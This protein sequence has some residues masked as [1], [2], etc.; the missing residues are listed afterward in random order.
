MTFLAHV[1]CVYFVA[2]LSRTKQAIED[3]RCLV[4]LFQASSISVPIVPIYLSSSAPEHAAMKYD[5]ETAV[6]QLEGLQESLD[7]SERAELE[8]ATG[9]SASK[10]GLGL[11]QSIPNIISKPLAIDSLESQFK[12]RARR[13]QTSACRY[14]DI[15]LVFICYT[16]SLM[17]HARV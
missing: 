13:G 1:W 8:K 6:S 16:L 17:V 4:H 12:V 14:F 3:P 11:A 7:P 9:V 2:I 5:F 10:V 15:L